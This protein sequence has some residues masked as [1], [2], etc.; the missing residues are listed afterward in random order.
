MWNLAGSPFDLT[1]R[2]AIVTGGGSGLGAVVVKGLAQ[3]G[4][5][6]AVI[7]RRLEACA[8]VA[9]Q[10]RDAGGQ[11]LPVAADITKPE[12]VHAAFEQVVRVL[13]PVDIL[14]NNAGI[15]PFSV[16]LAQ[17]RLAGWSKVLETNLTGALICTQAVV[18]SMQER[19]RG[20][21][22]NI[23]SVAG[24]VSSPGIGAYGVS[25]AGLIHLTRQL[26]AEQGPY[27]IQVNAIAPGYMDVG[28]SERIQN[29][30]AFFASITERTPMRRI[31]K[32]NEL[33]G[34]VILLASDA[35]SYI[36]GQTLFID[37]GFLA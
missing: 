34:A 19:K 8:E 11:A 2:V 12:S 17:T 7:G 35:S 37:G 27:N 23:A 14:V 18:G 6:V 20:K 13:G 3:G 30:E 26:A 10:V 29:Q 5:N 21:I 36:T 15:S 25:K 33:I 9:G 16:P 28:V 1:G 31:G 22:I 32:A 24:A 4:V